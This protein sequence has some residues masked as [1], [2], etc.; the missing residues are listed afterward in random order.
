MAGFPSSGLNAGSYF[1]S[2][3]EGITE[4]TVE[5]LEKAIVLHL[6]STE[7]LTFFDTSTGVLSSLLQK[8]TMPDSS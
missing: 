6:F 5:T 8:V 2:N 3:D 7:V 1:I 4:S